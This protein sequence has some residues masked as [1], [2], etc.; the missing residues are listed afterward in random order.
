MRRIFQK[1]LDMI[2]HWNLTLV[3]VVSGTYAIFVLCIRRKF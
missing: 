1:E 3:G 2:L